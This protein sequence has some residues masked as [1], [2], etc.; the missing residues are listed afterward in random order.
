[1][2]K[3]WQDYLMVILV[4]SGIQ[5]TNI[6]H[7]KYFSVM[8]IKVVFDQYFFVSAA[9]EKARDPKSWILYGSNDSLFVYNGKEVVYFFIEKKKKK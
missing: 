2:L 9:E 5:V 3:S 7:I 8:K 1:M 4:Q 6:I